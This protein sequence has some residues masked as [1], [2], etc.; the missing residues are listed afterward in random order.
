MPAIT[1]RVVDTAAAGAKDTFLWDLEVK[2]FGVKVT[3][4]GSKVYFVQYRIG[5]RGAPTRRVTIGKHGSPWTPALARKRARWVLG[6]VAAGRDPANEARSARL[7]RVN[8]FEAVAAEFIERYVKRR[9][10]RARETEQAVQRKLV[11]QWGSRPI[12]DIGRSDIL[13]LLDHEMDLGRPRTANK[14]LALVR[15]L[16][17]WAV[18]RGVVETSPVAGMRAPARETSRDRVLDE[19][20]L[21]RIWKAAEAM[22][23]PWAGLIHLLT[24]TA[25]RRNEVAQLSWDELDLSRRLWTLPAG[26]TKAGNT[27]DVPLSNLALSTLH[28]LPR[29]DGAELVFPASRVGSANAVSGF[30]KMK[31]RLDEL[32]G[33][34]AW[35]L[36]DLRRSA[37]SVMAAL[38]YPPHVIAG[39]LNHTPGSVMGIGAVY[40]RHRFLDERR[41]AL[42]AWGRHIERI[43]TGT[44]A[45]VVALPSRR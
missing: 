41:A 6:E 4:A 17:N 16:F 8:T 34:G 39:V 14:V 18:E 40:V 19:Q 42:D 23:W 30:S 38:G 2:G 15:K 26:R 33:V 24:A 11:A 37:A 28:G 1:K 36:H 7:A 22:G 29:V 25:Q 43:V 31:K 32:S 13:R 27:H 20:E 12:A 45:Q 3:P 44:S 9:H 21:G 5:G 10:R 35:R